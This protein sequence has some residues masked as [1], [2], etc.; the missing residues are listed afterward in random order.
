[1]KKFFTLVFL[2]S[3]FQ[4]QLVHAGHLRDHIQFSARING[5]QE[6]PAVTTNAQGV[7]T[8][9]LNPGRDTLCILGGFTGLSAQA[10]GAHLHEAG[11]GM[12]GSVV[13]DLTPFINGN[14]ISAAITG[15]ALSPALLQSMIKGN[16]YINIHNSMFPN[17]EIRGQVGQEADISF[18]A[19]MNGMQ[20]NPPV[21]VPAFGLATFSLSKNLSEL[22]VYTVLN[23]LSGAVTGAHL[24][25]GMPGMNGGVVSDLST[26]VSGNVISITVDPTTIL[27]DLMSG[28]LYINVHTA[29]NPGGEIRGQLMMTKGI[30]FDSRIDGNQEVPAVVTNGKATAILALSAGMDS[31]TYSIVTSGLSGSITGAHFHKAPVGT[32][33]AVVVDLSSTINGDK[34]A[35][36]ITGTTLN[37]MLINDLLKG[38]IYI[39]IHTAANPGGE[40]R[41]QVYRLL[42]EGYTIELNGAQEV[43]S[44]STTASGV[45]M[46]S[47]DRNQTNAHVMV[48]ANGLNA[49]GIHLHNAVAGQN[50]GVLF[51]L[52]P[53]YQNN[54]VFTYLKNT[55]ATPFATSNSVQLR[56]DSLY[57]NIHTA[58][59]PN[60]EIRGQV[61]RG[62]SCMSSITGTEE[63]RIFDNIIAYPN[64]VSNQ[65]TIKYPASLIG[66]I[67]YDVMDVMC[68]IVFSGSFTS[69]SGISDS[70]IDFSS[71]KSG[72]YFMRLESDDQIATLKIIKN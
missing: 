30:A 10:S 51:D 34:I 19:E 45:G 37:P 61:R 56:N 71:L 31:L 25:A 20:E 42:R 59:N 8:F 50:G 15:A 43:P 16:L 44:V 2:F 39:N 60:G 9:T 53:F 3:V 63:V 5:A 55:D 12:N 1:M 48:V 36:V 18:S 47:V 6:V 28:N 35:G 64:P 11:S 40:I 54:G 29:A 23:G 27:A 22:S 72:I 49:N 33:G 65:L 24:H 13:L 66:N 62:Y 67:S 7:A 52:T 69:N 38:E 41:G 46:I 4:I 70:E 26:G 17:G 68:R 58:A 57:V 32:A 14:T 21:I